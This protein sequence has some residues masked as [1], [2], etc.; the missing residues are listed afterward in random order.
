MDHTLQRIILI[1]S[2]SGIQH[3]NRIIAVC[4]VVAVK[5]AVLID[6]IFLC[7]KQGIV[8]NV[9]RVFSVNDAVRIHV[10]MLIAAG[11]LCFRCKRTGSKK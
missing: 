8:Q 9:D 7:A 3:I 10:T 4:L 5:V 2:Q 6:R 11:F 1:K